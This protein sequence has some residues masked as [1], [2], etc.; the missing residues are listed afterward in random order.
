MHSAYIR[1]EWICAVVNLVLYYTRLVRMA[2]DRDTPSEPI[3]RTR[4]LTARPLLAAPGFRHRRSE[5][6]A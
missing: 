1:R 5:A 4:Q 3:E 2:D 6:T